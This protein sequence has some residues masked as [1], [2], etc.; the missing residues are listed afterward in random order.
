MKILI[1]DDDT[2]TLRALEF[3][4]KK[5]GFEI[6]KAGNGRDGQKILEENSDI[7]VLITDIYMPSIGGLELVTYVRKTLKRNIPIVVLS[8]VNVEDTILHA[9]ELEADEY[10]L[11]PVD[12]EDILNRVKR[13]L[14]LNE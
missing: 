10:M 5:S 1:C 3:Q 12:L 2:M 6:L 7:D 9:F 14:K 8:R 11:K 4:F 13:L